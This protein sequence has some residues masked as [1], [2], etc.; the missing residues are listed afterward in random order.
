MIVFSKE[1]AYIDAMHK[2]NI[3]AQGCNALDNDEQ[4]EYNK[5]EVWR[6]EMRLW[7]TC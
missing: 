1:V 4:E 5:K 2:G 3:I 6:A 7:G